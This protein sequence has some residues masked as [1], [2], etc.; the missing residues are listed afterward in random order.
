MTRHEI[1]AINCRFANNLWTN[2]RNGEARLYINGAHSGAKV[3]LTEGSEGRPEL[4]WRKGY[5]AFYIEDAYAAL[6]MALESLGLTGNVMFAT[7]VNTVMNPAPV[8]TEKMASRAMKAAHRI[9]REAAE[10]FGCRLSEI[11]WSECLKMA[12]AEVKASR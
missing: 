12:W 8:L 2:H 11:R 10:R 5:S 6:D 3:W 1:N 9:R 4:N 7:I